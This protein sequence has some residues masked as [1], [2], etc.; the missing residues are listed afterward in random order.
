MQ[1]GDRE[2]QVVTEVEEEA[3]VETSDQRERR[4]FPLAHERST[5]PDPLAGG[6]AIN[7]AWRAAGIR[8]QVGATV[9]TSGILVHIF[10]GS[11]PV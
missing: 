5:N 9:P 8:R 6:C 4:R 3:D 10:G 1:S 7:V 11:R 2:E